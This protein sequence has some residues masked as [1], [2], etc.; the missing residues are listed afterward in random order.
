MYF[1]VHQE[2]PGNLSDW[3]IL[4]VHLYLRTVREQKTPEG[5]EDYEAF[6]QE[7]FANDKAALDAWLYKLTKQFEYEYIKRHTN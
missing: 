7:R 5:K 1:P 3:E 4:S 6:L 2:F